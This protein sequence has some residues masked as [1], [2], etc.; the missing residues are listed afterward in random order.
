MGRQEVSKKFVYETSWKRWSLGSRSTLEDNIKLDLIYFVRMEGE[1]RTL[2]DSG[3]R[4]QGIKVSGI[5]VSDRNTA[6]NFLD[7]HLALTD[8][9]DNYK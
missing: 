4:Y 5:F 7:L 3:L 2:P 6:A 8:L 1:Q 9:Q